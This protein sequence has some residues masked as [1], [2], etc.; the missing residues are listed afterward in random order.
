M[1]AEELARAVIAIVERFILNIGMRPAMSTTQVEELTLL[2][3][4]ELMEF[5]ADRVRR[6][7]K[8]ELGTDGNAPT[9]GPS[10]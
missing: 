7:V 1:S 8:E 4:T 3:Q 5:V 6:L 2:V 9:T 10:N